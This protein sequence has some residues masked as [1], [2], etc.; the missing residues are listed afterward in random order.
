M[1]EHEIFVVGTRTFATEVVGYATEAGFQVVGLLEAS[2]RGV[3]AR[4]RSDES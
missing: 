1:T 4:T 2:V 3:P